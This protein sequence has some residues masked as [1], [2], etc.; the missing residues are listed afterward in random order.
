[1]SYGNIN[2]APTLRVRKLRVF[3][4]SIAYA[5][6]DAVVGSAVTLGEFPSVPVCH[7]KAHLLEIS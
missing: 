5:N 4:L 1:M 2:K 6:A 3:R 7:Q